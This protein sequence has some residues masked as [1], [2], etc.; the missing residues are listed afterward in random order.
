MNATTTQIYRVHCMPSQ[1]STKTENH[2]QEKYSLAPPHALGYNS[3][4]TI[5]QNH[6]GG[7]NSNL[8]IARPVSNSN[9]GYEA[10]KMLNSK[11]AGNP[12][13]ES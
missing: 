13:K 8:K 7:S 1:Q 9:N 12:S 10:Q 3:L 2:R 11:T 4:Y 6:A 5:V